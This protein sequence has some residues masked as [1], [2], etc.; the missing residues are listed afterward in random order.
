MKV[1]V[2]GGP[3]STLAHAGAPNNI[4]IDATSVYWTDERANT[5]MKVPLDG[6]APFT[7]VTLEYYSGPYGI[8][9]DDT[10]VYWANA[11]PS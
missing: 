5:V 10:N 4:A 3:A 8:A 11:R 6:G 9:L 1:A 2:G 7:L